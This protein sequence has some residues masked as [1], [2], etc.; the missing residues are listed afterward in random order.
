MTIERRN[1]KEF[2][3][4]NDNNCNNDV[5]IIDNDNNNYNLL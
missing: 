2:N 1:N 5:N 4:I 3:H